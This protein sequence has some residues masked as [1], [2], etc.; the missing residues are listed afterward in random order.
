[1]LLQTELDN[2]WVEFPIDS[3]LGAAF[4]LTC[5]NDTDNLPPINTSRAVLFQAT[6]VSLNEDD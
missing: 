6:I 2:E 4:R 5:S 3:G 1:M